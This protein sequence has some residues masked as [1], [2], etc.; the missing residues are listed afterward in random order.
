VREEEEEDLL[1]K[2][3]HNRGFNFLDRGM[4]FERHL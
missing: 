4:W 2:Y 1:E 3:E